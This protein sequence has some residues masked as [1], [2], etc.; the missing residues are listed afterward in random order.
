MADAV[1]KHEVIE[2]EFTLKPRKVKAIRLSQD[3]LSSAADW[4]AYYGGKSFMAYEGLLVYNETEKSFNHAALSDY[5]YVDSDKLI[6]VATSDVFTRQYT[7][8][9]EPQSFS[10]PY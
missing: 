10:D 4:I 3:N 5:I 6:K 2:R 9:P 1:H 8:I 7:M